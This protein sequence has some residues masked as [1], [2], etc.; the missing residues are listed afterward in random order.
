[1]FQHYHENGWGEWRYSSTVFDFSTRWRWMVSFS[2]RS[3]FP[4]DRRMGRPQSLPGHYGEEKNCP[5]P[6]IEPRFLNRP[7]NSMYCLSYIRSLEIRLH[8]IS[9]YSV[10]IMTLTEIFPFPQSLRWRLGRYLET[11]HGHFLQMFNCSL[12]VYNLFRCYTGLTTA[13]GTASLN[14]VKVNKKVAIYIVVCLVMIPSRPMGEYK[15]F[16]AT[17]CLYLQGRN[18]SSKMYNM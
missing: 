12:F 8:I 4:F 9:R 11:D 13:A 6:W 5:L 15:R 14:N 3:L 7:S 18:I 1:M 16:G 10:P 2:L 17:C